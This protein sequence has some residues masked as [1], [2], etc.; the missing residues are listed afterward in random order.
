M[1]RSLRSFDRELDI[2]HFPACDD[3]AE[4]ESRRALLI[5]ERVKHRIAKD[6]FRPSAEGVEE[7]HGRPFLSSLLALRGHQRWHALD[8]NPLNHRMGQ[9]VARDDKP[10]NQQEQGTEGGRAH[11]DLGGENP[12]LNQTEL[13]WLAG[14]NEAEFPDPLP[15]C[16]LQKLKL[17]NQ[18]EPVGDPEEETRTCPRNG[19]QATDTHEYRPEPEEPE[20]IDDGG[21]I[22]SQKLRLF[23]HRGLTTCFYFHVGTFMT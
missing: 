16:S 15:E 23:S 19:C 21:Q 20:Q 3:F 8:G 17:R 5:R 12:F 9:E 11:P 10:R 22:Q 7:G 4:K 14:W 18:S 1:R 6:A 2:G 13:S